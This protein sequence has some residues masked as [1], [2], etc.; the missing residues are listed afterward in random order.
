MP[1]KCHVHNCL[2][3][4]VSKG[5][6][7]THRKRLARHGN[8]EQTRPAD[9]GAKEKHPAYSAWCSL[10]R[11]QRSALPENWAVD[12]WAF[13]A[14]VPP[15]PDGRVVAQRPDIRKPWAAENFYWKSS[16]VTEAVRANHAEYMRHYSRK[17]RAANPDYGKNV[18]LRRK[19][20]IGLARYNEMLV[21]QNN[22]C[23]ICRKAEV[24][25][26]R[27]RV[28][29]LAVDHDHKTG[30]V[31]ALLCSACNTALGL[32]NDDTALLDVAKAYL[33]QHLANAPGT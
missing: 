9:W 15:K 13:V 5:L 22:C 10:R 30:V 24:N 17:M 29:S 21:A 19:Y 25:E 14:D 20:G 6:C 28:V 16:I 33:Q 26:I 4:S 31:R 1:T 11:Y 3:P 27:G 32:F 23:A 18:F 8:T 7:D 12:F 2:K